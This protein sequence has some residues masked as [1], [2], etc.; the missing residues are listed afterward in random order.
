MSP[1]PPAV[2]GAEMMVL[3]GAARCHDRQNFAADDHL[4]VEVATFRAR[5]YL[6]MA[7]AQR[8]SPDARGSRS[9]GA[10]QRKE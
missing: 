3:G 6:V 1:E 2:R 4:D 9:R 5:V 10:R 8:H 7:S